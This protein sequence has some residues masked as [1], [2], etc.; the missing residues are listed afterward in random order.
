MSSTPPAVGIVATRSSMSS[1]RAPLLGDVQVAHDLDARDDR[2]PVARR[3]LD[4]GLEVAVLAQPDLGLRLARVGLDVDVRGAHL[5]GLNDHLVDQLDQLVVGGGRDLVAAFAGIHGLVI[6]TRQHVSDVAH[7]HHFRAVELIHRVLEVLH[8]GDA[9]LDPG[10]GK[11]VRRDARGANPFRIEAEHDQPLLRV[12]DRQPQVRLD[13]LALQVA[14]QV[15]RLDAIGLE[16]LIGHAEVLCQRLAD[17]GNLDLKLVDQ[18]GL[19]VH[20]LLARLARGELELAGGQHR[21]GD[22]VVVLGLDGL[23]LLALLEGDR[24]GLRQLGHA[25]FGEPAEGN[26]RLVVDELENP[27]QLLGFIEHRRDQHLLGAVAGALVDFLQEAQP[28]IDPAQLVVVVDV[29]DVE[30]ALRHAG[31]AG[32]RV[33]RDRQTQVLERVEAGLHLRDDRLLVLADHVNREPVGVEQR[34][35]VRAHVEDDL[36]DVV[37]R[38]DLVGDDLQ[39]LLEREPRVDV[40]LG[41]RR[42]AQYGAH[43][44]SPLPVCLRN[45][46]AHA[47][48]RTPLLRSR[49]SASM[50]A[51]GTATF[52]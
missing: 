39:L 35:D 38:V 50:L 43:K 27:D 41:G 26:T 29:L 1:L 45:R 10:P 22:Q 19:D 4:V 2:R 25:F 51:A 33:L 42:M 34:A 37:G 23:R 11:D 12:V 24:E 6:E 52:N 44:K 36:V 48:E 17:R 5:V 14:Q 21:I 49:L 8:G 3:N 40:A 18:H 31:I 28:G 13:V 20:R 16:R 9:V 32:D 7:V 15:H 47:R 30:H 46:R